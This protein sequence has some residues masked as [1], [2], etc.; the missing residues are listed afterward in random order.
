MDLLEVEIELNK[1]NDLFYKVANSILDNQEDIEDAIA[2][3]KYIV[4]KNSSQ[5]KDKSK[6]KSWVLTIFRNECNRVY[7]K[8]KE[9]KEMIDTTIDDE[10][11]EIRDY[12]IENSESRNN[13]EE[14]IKYLSDDDKEIFRLY[15][16][17][18]YTS[19]EIS[20]ITSINHNTVKSK[21]RRGKEKIR[22]IIS[23]KARKILTMFL[24]S[25]IITTGIVFAGTAIVNKINDS[26]NYSVLYNKNQVENVEYK[27]ENKLLI[28]ELDF[29][30]D[31]I[32][33]DNF[34]LT[35][36]KNSV[37]LID[38]NRSES[39]IRPK[40]I[41]WKDNDKLEITF[42][43]QDLNENIS[44]HLISSNDKIVTIVLKK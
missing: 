38:M 11:I 32:N 44:L 41:N 17:Y 31:E 24:I 2:E 19:E 13:F 10:N 43:F 16:Y 34:D 33:K 25:I 6:F 5:L 40:E 27:I 12:S 18:N 1:L 42:N 37:Y 9:D 14:L 26:K 8:N 39:M 21:L 36:N 3:T 15:F 20:E 28:V 4:I 29:K 35:W 23:S 22:R 30:E 7:N